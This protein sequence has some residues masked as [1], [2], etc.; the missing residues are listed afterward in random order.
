[1]AKVYSIPKELESELPKPNYG[2]EKFDWNKYIED[3]NAFV[4]KVKVWAK[5]NNPND[6]YAGAEYRIPMGDGRALYVVYSSKPVWLLYIPIGD[7]WNSPWASKITKKDIKL[8]I[9]R[10]KAMAELFGSSRKT[11]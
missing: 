10:S 8:E 9:E 4:E 5:K 7:A 3:E 1:M 2:N 11:L 6:E